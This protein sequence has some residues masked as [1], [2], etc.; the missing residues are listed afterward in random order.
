MNPLSAALSHIGSRDRVLEREATAFDAVA[1][2]AQ[3]IVIHGCGPLGRVALAGARNAGLPILAFSDNNSA[4]WGQRLDD[5]AIMSPVEA[6]ANYNDRA[7]FVIAVYNS[8]AP[9]KQLEQLG[10]RR[11]V[12]FPLFFWRYR[13][14]CLHETG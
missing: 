2:A 13:T 10:C 14:I 12:P 6:I 8:R 4:L 3:G 11:V 5:I 7:F 1:R 9:R